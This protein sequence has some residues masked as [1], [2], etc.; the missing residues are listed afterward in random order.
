MAGTGGRN[1]PKIVDLYSGCGGFSLGAELAGFKSLSA[2]DID[3]T[4]QSG[5]RRNFPGSKPIQAS[6]ADIDK[7]AWRHFIGSARPDGVIGGPPCQGFSWIGKRRKDDPRNSLLHHFYRHV[8]ILKPKFFVME[9]VVGLLDEE[10]IELLRGAIE[11]V[12]GR[13]TVLEPFIV[14]AAHYGA[15]TNRRRVVVF[16]YDPSE[17]DPITI[18]QLRP[19]PPTEFL[20]VREAIS[21]LPSPVRDR[22]EGSDFGWAEYPSKSVSRLSAYAQRM[23][24]KPKAGLGWDEA[25]DYSEKGFVSGLLTTIHSKEVARRYRTTR[26]GKTD[27]KTKSYRLEWDGQCPTL[28]AGT[29]ADKGAFQA[30]RPLHPGKGRVI[31]VREAARLQG[32]PDWFVF[33]PTKWHSFRMIGNS[34]SPVVSQGLMKRIAKKMHASLA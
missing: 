25:I 19:K 24:K 21:D 27:A 5:Y 30:V 15:A 1:Q 17:F 34:V 26:G 11:Q 33:H 18:D 7:S 31:T 6:V 10:N 2:I 8:G 9:N 28:R 13:Y 32:F 4:L 12:S 3:P 14:N 20:T 23:R 29:G 16:G 22:K